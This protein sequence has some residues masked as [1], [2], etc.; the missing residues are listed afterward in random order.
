[1]SRSWRVFL[2]WAL[3]MAL[4]IGVISQAHVTA[5]MSFFL[6][7][8]PTAEQKV[9]V[10]QLKDGSV[11]RLLML[12]MQGG[13]AL[14]RAKA[15]TALHD[16]LLKTGQFL[17]VQNGSQ[18]S[19]N[20]ERDLLLLHRYLLSPTVNGE[21]FSVKGL[22]ESIAETVDVLTSPAGLLIKPF[23]TKDPTGEL[24]SILSGLNPASQPPLEEG[25]WASRDGQRALLLLQTR[26][27]GSDMDGQEAAIE[28]VK[29]TFANGIAHQGFESL[30][31]QMSGPGVFAVNARAAIKQEVARLF[32]MSSLAIL[33][34]LW[35]VYRS[36]RLL[37]FG[38]MPVASAVVGGV[39]AVS[40]VFGT[41]FAITIGF[42][43]SLVGEAVDYAIYYFLQSA[44]G[45]ESAWRTRFWPTVRLGVLTTVFG[46]GAL[47]FS[48]FPGLAQLGL[49]SL[50][51]VVCAA[52]VTRFVLPAVVGNRVRVPEPGRWGRFIANALR[53]CGVI[54]WPLLALT[55]VAFA[56]LVLHH[57]NLWTQNLST[58]S[59]ITAQEAALDARLR[60]DLGAPDARYLVVIQATN[61]EQALI[62]AE[63]VAQRLDGLVQQGLIGGYDSP[64]RFLPSEAEQQRRREALPTAAVLRE[65][66]AIALVDSPLSASRLEAFVE[67][68]S[69]ARSAPLMTR[70]DLDGS[71]LS[72]AVDA[73]LNSSKQEEGRGKLSEWT[74][75]MPL[76]PGVD[77]L[78]EL[79]PT[80]L[81]N[82]LA[83]TGA[84]FIDRRDEFEA[85]YGQYI[86]QARGLSLAGLLCIVAL[87]A[88]SLR[89]VVKVAQVLWP[90]C[91]AVILV[92]AGLYASGVRLHLL[93]LIGL[94]LI[95][96]VGSNYAL[97]FVR[98]DKTSKM[99][100]LALMSLVTACMTGAIGFGVLV[101]SSVP[102]LQAIGVTVAPGLILALILAAAWR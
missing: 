57:G 50:V 62:G 10:D 2:I 98:G 36:P 64:A 22:R 75:L 7:S 18:V 20:Q 92:V 21:R 42:G 68:V 78:N 84:L 53:R 51:G 101:F 31:L 32:L 89:S 37:L 100:D 34:L 87:L 88:W 52:L 83:G 66:L 6:P 80:I 47:L 91:S 16:A 74:V 26:A 14:Q 17:T 29:A 23:V 58:L 60:K 73:L 25:V 39:V 86:A 94:L 40:W 63:R 55:A 35:G 13:D 85:L 46:F 4:G 71:A 93:H 9:L 8:R 65:R 67:A 77:A 79:S 49:H 12:S 95:F 54:E 45:G 59:S 11:S 102:V 41:V 33:I 99:D 43:T 27:L 28:T 56:Y 48:S 82:V 90:L 76:W 72:V 19:L 24:L 97:F 38:L 15:S 1:M 96:A 30:T 61:Q 5:D 70:Q 44:H 69:A 3:A 81:K